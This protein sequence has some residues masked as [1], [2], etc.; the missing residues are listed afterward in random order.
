MSKVIF[1]KIA[2]TPTTHAWSQTYSAGNFAALIALQT[3]SK[4][5]LEKTELQNIGHDIVST[6]EAEYF[7]LE[8]KNLA[9]IKNAV[10]L[11]S[12]KIPEDIQANL[13]ITT[14]VDAVFYGF[15]FGGGKIFI[16]RGEKHGLLLEKATLAIDI[17]A[18][19]PPVISTSGYLQDGDTVTIASDAFLEI[20]PEE[21]LFKELTKTPADETTEII[22]PHLQKKKDGAA[23][24]IILSY[25]GDTEKQSP[26]PIPLSNPTVGTAIAEEKTGDAIVETSPHSFL[27]SFFRMR[28]VLLAVACIIIVII[29]GSIFMSVRKKQLNQQ[30]AKFQTAYTAAQSKYDEGENLLALNKQEAKDDFT[31]VRSLLNPYRGKLP[32]NSTDNTLL[33]DLLRKTDIALSQLINGV[34]SSAKQASETD[35]PLLA[36]E[37]KQKAAYATQDT[38]AIYLADTNGIMAIDKTSQKANNIIKNSG[39]W[40]DVGGLGTYL[41]NMYLLDKKSTILKYVPAGS[42][43]GKSDYL[44]DKTDLSTATGI[45]IDGDMYVLFTDGSI[46]KFTKGVKGTFAITGLEKPLKNPSRIVTTVDDQNIYILDNGNGRVVVLNKNGAYQTQYTSDVLASAKDC[47]VLEKDKKIFILSQNKLWEVDMK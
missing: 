5:K 7:T 17:P 9:S 43:F 47:E 39:D 2:S 42:G 4:E 36:A 8:K 27:P 12:E 16:K 32:L 24:I 23:S 30:H 38:K 33:T 28:L 35:S 26:V 22:M 1:T 3:T 18:V 37:M 14:V 20:L 40:N 13:I 21:K 29:A 19:K 44:K 25:Q 6:L 34:A 31:S 46:Q 41:G 11:A 10:I 15:L 45:A